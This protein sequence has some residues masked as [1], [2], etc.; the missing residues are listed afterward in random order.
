MEVKT[1]CTGDIST[2]PG[3]PA[4]KDPFQ[5]L[6]DLCE[7]RL[8]SPKADSLPRSSTPPATA[9][10]VPVTAQSA[11][12]TSENAAATSSTGANPPSNDAL[13]AA[14][15]SLCNFASS[16]AAST[17]P[18]GDQPSSNDASDAAAQTLRDFASSCIPSGLS[19]FAISMDGV[20]KHSPSPNGVPQSPTGSSAASSSSS[21]SD[22]DASHSADSH[23]EASA[24][25][26]SI[27]RA[28]TPTEKQESGT[29]KEERP[30]NGSAKGVASLAYKRK[31]P[32]LSSRSTDPKPKRKPV[33]GAKQETKYVGVRCRW[34]GPEKVV[35]WGAEVN[36]VGI[37]TGQAR[38][39][40]F[41]T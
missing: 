6:A 22:K 16:S 19:S 25:L 15:Q 18:T 21:K 32:R 29:V 4:T 23:L 11:A 1:E 2:D 9:S 31:S 24:T 35:V 41:G 38:E 34:H 30:E 36:R 20:P 40:L 12:V 37:S 13:D 27:G 39:L 7:Q 14:A 10:D 28:T 17:G 33:V 5:N 26:S 8:G 3:P